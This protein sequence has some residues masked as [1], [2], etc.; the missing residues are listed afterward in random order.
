MNYLVG[1]QNLYISINYPSPSL[2]FLQQN[3]RS[4]DGIQVIAINAGQQQI[5]DQ[6]MMKETDS[7]NAYEFNK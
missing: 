6:D 3:Q 1:V 7:Q 2:N 5:T 4:N